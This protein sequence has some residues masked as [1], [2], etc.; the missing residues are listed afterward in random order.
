MIWTKEKRREYN[1]NYYQRNEEEIKKY[2]Q[3]EKRKKYIKKYELQNKD[4]IR[5]R[6]KLYWKEYYKN[7]KKKL[8]I[9]RKEYIESNREKVSKGQIRY[10]AN[11]EKTDINYKLARILR[12]RLKSAIKHNYKSGSAVRD[13]GC[14]ISYLKRY[15]EK[16]FTKGMTWDNHG[17][18]HI[19]HIIPLSLVNLSDIE[20]LLK[21]VH[22]KNLQPLWAKDNLIKSN[23]I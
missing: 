12:S 23:K 17:E 1:K 9:K 22:Y 14:T 15:L 10:M 20:Q 5:K 4:R 7:N 8:K 16:Q 19:D 13:L 6:K 18:W 3:T 2:R 11:R 21:V